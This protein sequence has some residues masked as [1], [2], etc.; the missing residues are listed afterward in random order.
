M[1]PKHILYIVGAL[2][3]L[4]GIIFRIFFNFGF[5][6]IL[7][8]LVFVLAIFVGDKLINASKSETDGTEF[9]LES[10]IRKAISKARQDKFKSEAN[11]NKLTMWAQETIVTAYDDLFPNGT[12]PFSKEKAFE[13]YEKIKE[14]YGN[15]LTFEV[16]DKCDNVVKGYINQIELEK[17][18][19]KVFDKMQTEYEAMKEK[20]KI[21][22]QQM[23][24]SERVGK[25]ENKLKT[26]Q[27]DTSGLASAI[28]NE[29]TLDNLTKEVEL[30]QEYFK[31]LEQLHYE[32]GDDVD[33]N[34][35][36]EYKT[37]V[38]E[39]LKDNKTDVI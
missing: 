2:I 6:F 8:G 4:L 5:L 35:A 15:K 10:Q 24:K 27:D 39:I 26:M 37:K 38:D 20:I 21:A 7:L 1:K 32:Y 33:P 23:K 19:I 16:L 34:K 17:S 36:I 12:M 9:E 31:Q 14:E 3:F 13:N 18:K 22:K 28:N 11:I 30:K 25:Y 29:Y